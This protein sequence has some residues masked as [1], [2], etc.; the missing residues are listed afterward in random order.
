MILKIRVG[1]NDDICVKNEYRNE[2]Y[3]RTVNEDT[4]F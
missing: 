4:E 2:P 1:K 3:T